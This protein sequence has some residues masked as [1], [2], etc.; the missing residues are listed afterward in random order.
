M[1][2][3][4]FITSFKCYTDFMF[5]VIA[6]KLLLCILFSFWDQAAYSVMFIVKHVLRQMGDFSCVFKGIVY[7][8]RML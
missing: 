3:L 4:I 7:Y 1:L 5:L 8:Y 6:L 2:F